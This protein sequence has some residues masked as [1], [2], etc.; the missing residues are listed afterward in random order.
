MPTPDEIKQMAKEWMLSF[1]QA[2][3]DLEDG[4]EEL[5]DSEEDELHF[6]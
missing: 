2:V 3:K 1:K 6:D 4:F 5:P